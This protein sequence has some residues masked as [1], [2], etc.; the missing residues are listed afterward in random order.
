ML[1]SHSLQFIASSSGLGALGVSWS[2]FIIQ[3]ITFVLA[4]LVLRKYAFKPIIK[5][6]NERKQ[7]IDDGVKLGEEMRI[8]ETELISQVEN[9]LSEARKKADQ[10][11]ALAEA[12]SKEIVAG[13]EG[14]ASE[15]AKNIIEQAELKTKQDFQRAKKQLEGEIVGLI[16]NVAEEFTKEKLNTKLDQERIAKL[17]SSKESN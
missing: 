10:I 9:D 6:L 1:S 4:Y 8:K 16:G 13:A 7:L 14:K 17:L 12:N 5:M 11:I 15:R 3:L 2:A